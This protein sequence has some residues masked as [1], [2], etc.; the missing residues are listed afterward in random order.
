MKYRVVSVLKDNRPRFLIISDIE[1]IEILPSKYLKHLDQINASPN[2]VKSAAFA[3]SYYYNYLQEQ[4][5]G[6]DEITLLSYSEQNKHFIDF[7]YWVKSGKH[8]EHNTQTSNK[9][10]N[11]YLGA[12]FRYYQFLALEDVLPMLKVLRVKKVSYFDSMGVNHQNAVNSFKGFFKEEE[13]N[14]EEITSEEIQELINA[15]TNDRDRLL[16]AMM[17][18]TGL[19]LGEILGI[20]YTED[21]D[22]ERRTVRVRYMLLNSYEG[23]DYMDYSRYSMS[24]KDWG[25]VFIKSMAATVI[26]AYL[27]YDSPIVVIAFPAVFA[28]CA[29]L[30]RQEG[31]RRQKEKLNEEF[32]NVLKVLSSNMLAGYSVENAWQEAEKEM[33]LMYGNDSLML[34]EIQ[35]MNRQIKMNQTF[36]AV[37]SE[38][39]HRSGL[40]DIVNFSDIFSFA[41]RS[42]GRFVDIIGTKKLTLP[43]EVDGVKLSWSQEKSNT[44]AK[45]AMLEV[46]VIVLLVLEKK[47]KKKTAQKERNIQLQLE[48]PEIVSKMAVLMGSGMTVEQAWNR[49]TARYLDERKNNDKNIMPAYEEMLVTEREISDGVTGRKAYAD[50]AERVKLP[51]YQKFV[52]IILQSIHKGSKGVCEMLEKESEDAFDERRLLA[53]KL[54]EEAGTKMLMPMMIMM[55]IVIAIVIAPAIID[56]KI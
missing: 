32:M 30:C 55:A 36:E 4:T 37:L 10:C 24:T 22:F 25:I 27:F 46:V 11:M 42:G 9:T 50:F 21:I 26:I 34:S 15:C 13:P 23:F 40:E 14:L 39:A 1:E 43:D 12:V 51:C 56:F 52:R 7:L 53:L 5:I 33:E 45:I 20:H 3:L 16:I 35:E 31:V 2:T 17:A 47:E 6:L 48:Y 44:A 19:R 54:G 49:I 18:E 28:Y 29:K 38:F 8:T 41:K